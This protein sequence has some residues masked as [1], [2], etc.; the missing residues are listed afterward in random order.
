MK[1]YKEFNIETQETWCFLVEGDFSV[2]RLI[3]WNA[4]P[5]TVL[6]LVSEAME[7]LNARMARNRAEKPTGEFSSDLATTLHAHAE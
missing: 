4:D 1:L 7:T 5:S 3:P 2:G 6:R